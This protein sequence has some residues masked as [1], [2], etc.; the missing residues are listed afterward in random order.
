MRSSR[1]SVAVV[2]EKIGHGAAVKPA[3]VEFPL[4]A[5]IQQ[6]ISDEG[7]EHLEPRRTFL[8]VGQQRLPKGIEIEAVPEFQRKPTAAP[9]AWTGQFD[10]IEEKKSL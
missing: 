7:F 8:R 4:A 9:L 10:A 6:A 2:V 5:G 1:L 3:A